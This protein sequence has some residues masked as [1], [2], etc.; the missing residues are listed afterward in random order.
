[1][2]VG[3][4]DKCPC[5]SGKKYKNCCLKKTEVVQLDELRV[6]RFFDLKR[7]LVER[8][9]VETI[10]TV[11]FQ[12]YHALSVQFK[13]RV[14]T[15]IPDAYFHHWLM[16][17]Y[18]YPEFNG[19][20]GIEFY[21]EK[22]ARSDI[23]VLQKM[24]KVW[25]NMVPRL[26]Q[27]VDYDSLGVIV[28]D[29]FTKERFHMPYCETLKEWTPWGGTFMFL[30][31]FSEGYYMNG[32]AVIVGP[33]GVK[34]ALDYL[35][36][37]MQETG[38]SYDRVA[39][40]FYP[41]VTGALLAKEPKLAREEKELEEVSLEYRVEE[42]LA[43]LNQLHTSGRLQ[44]DEWDGQAGK[45]SI[46]S[47]RYRYEDNAASGSVHLNVVE[48]MLE[49]KGGQISFKSLHPKAIDFFKSFMGNFLSVHLV[50]EKKEVIRIPSGM[51][52]SFYSVQLDK[53]VDSEFAMFAQQAMLLEQI[54][55]PLPL[56]DGKT[57]D[58]MAQSGKTEEL[59]QWLREQE[60]ASH[61]NVSNA[62]V[63][64]DF[65]TVRAKLG[66]Q[67]SPF[68]TLRE[69][70]KT[71]ITKIGISYARA[72]SY[73]ID[74]QE[75]WEEMGNAPSELESFYAT[76]LIE[77]FR[78]KGVGKSQNTYYKYRLGCMTISYFL[79]V[80]GIQSWEE[81][82]AEQWKAL[83]SYYYLDFNMDATI[84]QMK[85]FFTAIKSL[86]VWID[87][88]YGT[89]HALT[90]KGLVMELE[91]GISHVIKLL[92]AYMPYYER[93]Y[94]LPLGGEKISE[95]ILAN[96]APE[97]S[98]KG[99]FQVIAAEGRKVKLK[100]LDQANEVYE[101]VSKVNYV[102]RGMIIY[103]ALMRTSSWN[104]INIYRVFPEQ[105]ASFIPLK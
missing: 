77:F 80:A 49:V 68:T 4:N 90:V 102:E 2:V 5:G 47:E 58:Q 40:D 78:E 11:S 22:K 8:L 20:R 76:D 33:D 74:D 18:R 84:H 64:A 94:E 42:V 86:T 19:L 31:E 7:Q 72:A 34:R 98:V 13:K 60:Y 96:N 99:I 73:S 6:E 16:F 24:A 29:V 85:G 52:A 93:R 63:T 51:D 15:I 54:D 83:I 97:E 25:E 71:K 53:G 12:G 101:T 30:E 88:K 38:E 28:E 70:R 95:M 14:N 41:E 55:Q 59:E 21:N 89:K 69:N 61:F 50:E 67:A 65:N 100:K 39:M 75:V 104:L 87:Q 10:D 23:P 56:F 57:P 81:I 91:P 79:D 82:S 62:K 43:V 9:G 17:F 105:A 44:M 103:G 36:K 45:G 46:I 1:M 66:L 35:K 26:I 48:G 37:K 32:V 27:H 3:R 92:D